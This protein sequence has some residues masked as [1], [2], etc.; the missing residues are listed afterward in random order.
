M[1]Q[2][3][4]AQDFI[5]IQEYNKEFEEEFQ[6]Q[7][8]NRYLTETYNDLLNREANKEAKKVTFK[9]FAEVSFFLKTFAQ[10]S[11]LPGIIAD[12][13]FKVISKD[14][15]AEISKDNFINGLI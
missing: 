15:K 3:R 8:L 11:H 2:S 7:V 4:V 10:Y 14:K 9:V 13:F 5:E 6:K 1:E 12:R